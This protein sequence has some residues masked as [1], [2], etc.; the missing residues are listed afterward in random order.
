VNPGHQFWIVCEATC[1]PK[2]QRYEQLLTDP[3]A[4]WRWYLSGPLTA[5]QGWHVGLA[6]LGCLVLLIGAQLVL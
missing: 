2:I 1:L 6:L 3:R 4:R 5:R